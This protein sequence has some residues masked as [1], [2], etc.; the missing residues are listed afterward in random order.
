MNRI[1]D[2]QKAIKISQKL[3]REGKTIV[4]AGGVFDILHLGH[5]KFLKA[6]KKR[7][8]VLFILLENDKNVKNYKGINR[9]INTQIERAEILTAMKPVDY[10]I[11]LDE[12][13]S[14]SDYDK[15]IINFKPDV[16][17]AT[18]NSEQVTHNKRQAKL[19]NAQL[20]LVI[21]RIPNK[22]TTRV[23]DI[24]SQENNL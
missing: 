16:I 5:I 24:I 21:N 9:P 19:V 1:I 23:A 18:K 13:K 14:N 11:K 12:M 17:A 2:T 15:L 22:S 20:A 7:G 3:K 6:G 10:V 8:D 4:L